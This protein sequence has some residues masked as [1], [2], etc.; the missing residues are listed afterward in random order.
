MYGRLTF[1]QKVSEESLIKASHAVITNV[2]EDHLEIMGPEKKDVALAFSGSIPKSKV[3]FTSEKEFFPFFQK[4]CKSKNTEIIGTHLGKY[5]DL[6]YMQ[7]FAYYEHSE[8]VILALEVCEALGVKPEIAIKGMWSHSPDLGASFFNEYYFGKKKIVFANAF[9]AND[10]RS[11]TSIWENTVLQFPEYGYKVAIVNCRKD[12]PERSEQMAKEILS[13]KKNAPD[14]ILIVGEETGVFKKTCLKLGCGN[15]KL[16]DLKGIDAK[17]ILEF[18]ENSLPS[19]TLVV[20]LG[21]IGG[22]GLELLGDFKT[23]GNSKRLIW[24]Y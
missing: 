4:I 13:W 21:N 3:L 10:P 6:N 1:N 12:R 7:G 17:R 8:N 15:S 16:V 18:F 5:S 9:A 23:Q 24:T 2:R 14:L 19:E 22:L 20:G 11:A